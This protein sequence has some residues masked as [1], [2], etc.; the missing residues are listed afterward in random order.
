MSGKA[1]YAVFMHIPKT[2]GNCILASLSKAPVMATGHQ[3]AQGSMDRMVKKLRKAGLT[4]E[5]VYKFSFVRNPWDRMV[6]WYYHGHKVNR[7]G[8]CRTEHH[9]GFRDWLNYQ[10]VQQL[11][12][13]SPEIALTMG[14]DQRLVPDFVGQY[15]HLDRDLAVVAE[16]LCVEVP[17]IVLSNQGKNRPAW[18]RDFKPFYDTRTDSLI[19]ATGEWEIA[20]FRYS[21]DDEPSPA[22]V[23]RP[24]VMPG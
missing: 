4:W 15:E 22:P 5:Q 12:K 19:V 6:S 7:E 13:N 23:E 8:W 11:M 20:T 9:N 24:L 14:A 17:T 2:G 10:G 18:A 16:A 1:R 21:R 3:S